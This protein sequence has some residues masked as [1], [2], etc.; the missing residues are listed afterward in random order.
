MLRRLSLDLAGLPPSPAE[1]DAF[2]AD[3]SPTAYEDEVD[4]L[5]A[6]PLYGERM[7]M[8]WLDGARFADTNGYQ[9]DF[10]RT[11]WPWRDW[12][13]AAF[14]RNQPFDRFLTEQ[15]AGDL[16]PGAT[17]AQ[18]IATG[19]NRNNRTVT[20]A[21]S[22]EEEWRIENA[23]DRVETTATV[24]LGL[25]MG[26]A[27]C[28][29]HKFDPISQAEFY[30]FLG[31][32]NSV[33]EQGRVHRDARQRTAAGLAAD[34]EESQTAQG[35]RAS[36]S[37]PPRHAATRR[38]CG[39]A[40]QGEGSRYEKA[41]TSVMVMEDTAKPRPTYVL[42][43]GQYDMP[44]KS[45]P[46]RAGRSLVSAA[47]AE[48][49][50][51]ETG[52]AWPLAGLAG[53]PADRPGRRQPDLAAPFRHGA[54]EDRRELRRSGR[55]AL[56]PR[57]ARLAGE[58]ADPH[59]VGHE[60]DAPPDR[61]QRHVPATFECQCRRSWRTTRKTA[62]SRAGRGSGWRPRWC[63]T[64][65]WRSPGC[66]SKRLGGPSVKPY[67]PAG[68]WEELAGGA[69]RRPTSR[70]RGRPLPPQP[71]RLSQTDRAA[72]DHGDLRRPQ[73]RG[74]PGQAPAHQYAAPGA[75]AAQRPDLRRGRPAARPA[76]TIK[77]A[78]RPTTQR[79]GLRVPPRAGRL[80]SPAELEVLLRG[81]EELSGD[82]SRRPRGRP[83]VDPTWRQPA[84]N[85]DRSRRCWRPIR[86]PA[87]SS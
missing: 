7:A 8:D 16:L 9:N 72:S 55:A 50:S 28:H 56:A 57:A 4:R 69:V 3:G 30:Q 85:D 36:R 23:V 86:P 11:M 39:Q 37:R 81:L 19:F 53:E 21:G 80:P 44:D 33:N 12:V 87:G 1:V 13:I 64:M 60:G 79:L 67:Q 26:C 82:L 18:K 35:A 22:I 41:I 24:F 5:L 29:D 27:R 45:R 83:A 14:N 77:K 43:R 73:P 76:C 6:S 47:A 46:G 62:C 42:K 61:H 25:T 84:R 75:R 32:F 66:S 71:V 17:L 78:A 51:R 68:L 20:E 31:F 70:T 74:L 40:R 49:A 63:A 59:R 65:P 15:I 54:G 2:L 58:R 10:A 38:K 48:R 34:R 52:S